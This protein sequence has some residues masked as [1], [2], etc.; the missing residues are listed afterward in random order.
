MRATGAYAPETVH[1]ACVAL[2]QC[3]E[4][5]EDIVPTLLQLVRRGGVDAE[6]RRG[7]GGGK[8]NWEGGSGGGSG[9]GSGG[10]SGGGT[11][12]G[13]GCGSVSSGGAG[14]V[15]DSSGV[16]TSVRHGVAFG[17]AHLCLLVNHG[18]PVVMSRS[19]AWGQV[20]QD[21]QLAAAACWP[22]AACLWARVTARTL[23]SLILTPYESVQEAALH[24]VHVYVKARVL[25][26]QDAELLL[27]ALRKVLQ[28]D[29][30]GGSQA[31]P[32]M[33][34]LCLEAIF[35]AA[36]SSATL[37]DVMSWVR[38]AEACIPLLG[39]MLAVAP[40]AAAPLHVATLWALSECSRL[41]LD[42]GLRLRAR[43]PDMVIVMGQRHICEHAPVVTACL[44]LRKTDSAHVACGAMRVLASSMELDQA[45][46]L[47]TWL[48]EQGV[49]T[50]AKQMLELPPPAMGGVDPLMCVLQ[51][52]YNAVKL[53]PWL[54]SA[55]ATASKSL[56]AEGPTC[57]SDV[58]H[59]AVRAAFTSGCV[60]KCKFAARVLAACPQLASLLETLLPDMMQGLQ[61]LTT[62]GADGDGDCRSA[63]HVMICAV[64]GMV[65]YSV[66]TCARLVNVQV[67]AAAA[68]GRD[69]TMHVLDIAARVSK[70]EYC[71]A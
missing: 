34:L 69:E 64:H 23:R 40:P 22:L 49:W 13:T 21:L 71:V 7:S 11:G 35:V 61:T 63:I 62:T 24:L 53:K 32:I 67:L 15:V 41:C 27:P 42:G 20:P 9:C 52:A 55:W 4:V 54:D 29:H 2:R 14:G 70:F 45:P 19:P 1:S 59:A 47:R 3:T 30:G 48:T 44:L 10:G 57:I 39:A 68:K 43:V 16:P 66:H 56:T 65:L 8:K 26:M 33:A 51:L 38:H 37:K 58:V 17:A 28:L 25:S 12:C 60:H 18:V 50:A 31:V 36:K 6:S 46:A 5:E